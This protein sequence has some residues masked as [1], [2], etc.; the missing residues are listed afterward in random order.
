[1]PRTT[2]VFAPARLAD[3][4]P[5][6]PIFAGL[7]GSGRVV[8]GLFRE[9][10][11]AFEPTLLRWRKEHA[12]EALAVPLALPWGGPDGVP[13]AALRQLGAAEAVL[14]EP[15]LGA[16]L[17]ARRAGCRVRWGYAG[18]LAGLLLSR[19][20][21][22]P[23]G[24]EERPLAEREAELAAALGAP[25]SPSR[26]RLDVPRGWQAVGRERLDRAKIDERRP[27]IG[28]Y[29]GPAGGDTVDGWPRAAFEELLRAL[30]K[31]RSD[32]QFVLL[33]QLEDLWQAVQLYEKT[34]KIHPVIGPDLPFTGVLAT[35]TRL[36]LLVAADSGLLHLA[37]ALGVPT[38]GLYE[39]GG[40]RHPAGPGSR[41]LERLPLRS[42]P[43]D[44]VAAAALALLAR[45]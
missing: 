18:G 22:R 32:F 34:G 41:N 23:A 1:V 3:A 44:E 20:V 37:A 40:H 14:L 10:L 12:P 4:L 25:F 24:W 16:G 31:E 43:P 35:L 19:R 2:L 8:V 39:K 45:T 13:M 11:A 42:L 15:S 27:V 5:R 38:L 17:A 26:V 7:A 29:A 9:G 6:L 21:P 36:D 33:A 30:R 28:I